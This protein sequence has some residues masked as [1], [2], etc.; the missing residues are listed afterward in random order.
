M[1]VVDLGWPWYTTAIPYL[2]LMYWRGVWTWVPNTFLCP[3]LCG[4][5]W[6]FPACQVRIVRFNQR[7]FVLLCPP[8]PCPSFSPPSSLLAS[9]VC[10]FLQNGGGCGPDCP[11]HFH[12]PRPVVV[13]VQFVP[14]SNTYLTF[15]TLAIETVWN[16]QTVT[17]TTVQWLLSNEIDRQ[18]L[19]RN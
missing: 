11:I 18:V 3:A 9:S 19:V 8:P 5:S 13:D 2:D 15:Y 1:I 7:C 12:V 4:C 10:F 6:L 16:K 14:Y 17:A